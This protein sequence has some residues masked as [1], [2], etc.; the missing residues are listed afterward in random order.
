[1][2][3][4]SLKWCLVGLTVVVGALPGCHTDVNGPGVAATRSSGDALTRVTPITPQ[5][6]AIVRR[7][8]Q[9]GHVEAFQSSPLHAKVSGYVQRLNADIGD[10]V[11]GPK[12]EGDEIVERGQVLAVLAVPEMIEER[13]QREALIDQAKAEVKQAAAA[14][15]VAEAARGSAVAL[16]GEAKAGV[17]RAEANYLR[18][19]SELSRMTEL[20]ATRSVTAKLE[21]ETRNQHRA[22]DAA[23]SEVKAQIESAEARLLESESHIEK[24]KADHEAALAKLKVA[25]SELARVQTVLDYATIRAP[26]DGIVTARNI[27]VGHLVSATSMKPLFEVIQADVVR[28]FVD[29]PEV[30]AVFI[31]KGNEAAIR[32]PSLGGDAFVGEIARTSWVLTEGT[33]TLRAEIDV[34]NDHGRLRPGMYVYADVKV[35]ERKEAIVLPQTALMQ[36]DGKSFCWQVDPNGKVLRTPVTTGISSGGEVEIVAGLTGSEQVI[37]VNPTSFREGQLVEIASPPTSTAAN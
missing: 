2:K 35:A 22:A 15:A 24:A 7:A 4:F 11:Q 32:V 16:V 25:E 17:E 12:Y 18:W 23:R 6:K 36:A 10:R 21:E 8:E 37:G 29:V 3:R 1:M 5:R 20:V 31:E 9:P 30:D 27:D 13:K 34:P 33:R 19:Q 28:V 26:F 14:I